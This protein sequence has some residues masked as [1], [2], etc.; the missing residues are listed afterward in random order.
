MDAKNCCCFDTFTFFC[1]QVKL[2]NPPPSF[3]K[4]TMP[5]RPHHSGRSTRRRRTRST[6]SRSSRS[7]RSR[8]KN[9]P[10]KP[11]GVSK[12]GKR[13]Y[14][15]LDD[16][17]Y[18]CQYRITQTE[19]GAGVQFSPFIFNASVPPTNRVIDDFHGHK[20]KVSL[21]CKKPHLGCENNVPID[22]VAQITSYYKE[23]PVKFG[24]ATWELL[25]GPTT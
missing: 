16:P 22:R 11:R 5:R 17:S 6:R 3:L 21:S 8:P 24:F 25:S 4:K 20:V 2:T 18:P 1:P 10:N 7:N 9:S 23:D 12:R 15:A 14:R 19:R 13:S